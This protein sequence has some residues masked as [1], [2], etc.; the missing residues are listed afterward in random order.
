MQ[1]RGGRRA[2]GVGFVRR[3]AL[4]LLLGASRAGQ[5]R[6]AIAEWAQGRRRITRGVVGWGAGRSRVDNGRESAAG[7]SE[8][9]SMRL[10]GPRRRRRTKRDQGVLRV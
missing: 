2:W 7:L 8:F 6:A 4:A 3:R 1:D 10:G 5:Q 9:I